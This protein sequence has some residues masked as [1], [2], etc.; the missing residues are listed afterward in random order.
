[1]LAMVVALTIP[2]AFLLALVP[3]QAGGVTVRLLSIGAINFGMLV[4]GSVI[5]A[6]QIVHRLTVSPLLPTAPEVRLE[7]L[8]QATAVAADHVDN[9]ILWSMLIVV[10]CHVPLLFLTSIEGLIFRPMIWVAI[11]SLLG[12]TIYA[13]FVLP[14]LATFTIYG[15]FP[16]WENP[17]LTWLRPLYG[18]LL[19]GL[20]QVR[21]LMATILA[22]L[23]V[24]AG[25]WLTPRLG[26]EFLPYVDEG[27]MWIR[28]SFPPGTSLDQTARFADR[29]R[30][31]V[32][33][34]PEV[35]FA[36]SQ[37][38]RNDSGTD[39]FSPNR[40]EIMVGLKP[41]RE[42]TV[43]SQTELTARL[44]DRLRTEFPTI[45]FRFSQPIID[46]VTEDTNGTSADL[47]VEFT[48]A[49]LA[50]LRDLGHHAAALLEQIPG[51]TDV[52]IEQDGP[53]S[54]FVIRPD[55]VRC[56]QYDVHIDDVTRLIST[57]LGGEPV[58]TLYE[59]DRRFD[60]VVR[61]DRIYLTSP[62][63]IGSLPVYS[64]AGV[65][66]P[67]DQVAEISFQNAPTIIARD[68]GRRRITVRC[69]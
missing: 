24:G 42:W 7:Q 50:I 58:G 56:A 8:Q 31:I 19:Q 48:G 40:L 14:A 53:Q 5:M 41:W 34:F 69:E 6:D 27:V 51:A 10:A 65:P 1:M 63:A 45:R 37:A 57:A 33:E 20:L 17:L 4:W 15:G 25:L 2:A 68:N 59:E 23:V 30:A 55:R 36:A 35:A 29:L 22:T 13:L 67:L 3:I 61:F 44:G 66:L 46:S 60:I 18:V 49:D 52:Q 32:R 64:H 28:A 9:P 12:A 11:L 21:W 16:N 47:A 26:V 38:G 39:P 62:E 54:Q 43:P